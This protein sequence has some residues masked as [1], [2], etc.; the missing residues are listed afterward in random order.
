MKQKNYYD[1]LGVPETAVVDEI[2][3]AY[4]K[5]AKE[6]H[7]DRN[8]GDAAAEA[9]FKDISEAYEVLSDAGKRKK[10]DELR[11]YSSSAKPGEMSFDDFIRRF[12]G[13]RTGDEREFTWVVSRTSSP[14]SSEVDVPPGGHS[15]ADDTEAAAAHARPGPRHGARTRRRRL[16]RFSAVKA[17]TRGSRSR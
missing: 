6:C 10:Y 11:R 14:H 8:P 7:P 13:E 17:W 12:G 5:L 1:I 2:K 16:I 15:E 3:A 4:R 9:R